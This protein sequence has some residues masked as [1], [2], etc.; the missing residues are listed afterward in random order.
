M[1]AAATDGTH[2]GDVRHTWDLA[3]AAAAAAVSGL[4]P[5]VALVVPAG[6]SWGVQLSQ[7][8]LQQACV[9]CAWL[10]VVD[11]GAG[12]YTHA[13]TEDWC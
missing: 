5:A 10:R 3:A 4:Q 9:C 2:D 11:P 1:H 6:C 7:Q 8:L 12:W 13:G